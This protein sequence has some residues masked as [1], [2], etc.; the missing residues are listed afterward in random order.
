MKIMTKTITLIL[1]AASS[2]CFADTIETL[3]L[4]DANSFVAKV[5][6]AEGFSKQTT[7]YTTNFSAQE[8]A[9]IGG[10]FTEISGL[11]SIEGA[12]IRGIRL[13]PVRNRD[14]GLV[15]R[16]RATI[17]FSKNGANKVESVA[18]GTL[19]P[20]TMASLVAMWNGLEAITSEQLTALTVSP[21]ESELDEVSW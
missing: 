5:T 1:L 9:L 15:E 18:Q 21:V 3:R 6:D 14:T 7:F 16:V 8:Q 11:V 4:S 17:G 2:F 13:N 20:S 19:S 10:A 12:T